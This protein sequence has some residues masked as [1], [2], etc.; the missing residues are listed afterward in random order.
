MRVGENGR[1][2]AGALAN[3]CT[4]PCRSS[5]N[6]FGSQIPVSICRFLL[7]LVVHQ[8]HDFLV[9]ASRLQTHASASNG[10][11]RRRAPTTCRPAAYNSIAVLASHDESGFGQFRDN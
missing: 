6:S 10:D 8:Q 5:G 4:V 2:P 9:L 7:T 11:E 1:F 3:A